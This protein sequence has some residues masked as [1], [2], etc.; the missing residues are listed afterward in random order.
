MT[1]KM[2]R[3][4][5]ALVVVLLVLTVFQLHLYHYLSLDYLQQRQQALNEID[6]QFPL[7]T[8]L[9]FFLLY[10]TATTLSLPGSVLLTLASGAIF[11]F[12]WGLLL[13]SFASSI[14]G[15][16]AFG[17]AR[18][19]LRDAVRQRFSS[20]LDDINRGLQANGAWYLFSLRLL[21]VV[22]YFAINLAMGLTTLPA[23]TFY[24]VS[25]IG[26]L[27][28]T[29]LYV[30]AGQQ[31]TQLHSLIDLYRPTLMASFLL[32]AALPLVGLGL[33]HWWQD[34]RAAAPWAHQRHPVGPSVL[35]ESPASTRRAAWRRG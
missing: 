12:G 10:V 6:R 1:M 5:L 35:P 3:W 20:Q 16:L 22:P 8:R 17:M 31:L 33:R 18:F 26:M 13:S 27:S 25:Q 4:I 28:S 32:L 7:Q 23:R 29:A 19:V 24:L 2:S 34:R 9:L 30:N 21:P 14:G 11:G 15:L